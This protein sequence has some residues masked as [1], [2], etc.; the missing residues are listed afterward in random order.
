MQSEDNGDRIEPV[1]RNRHRSREL[2]LQ[3]LYAWEMGDKIDWEVMLERIADGGSLPVEV[4]KYAR[5]LVR[6]T[7][8]S[9]DVI[10]TQVSEQAANWELRR[11]AA[12]DR[13]ILRL[14]VAELTWFSSVPYKVVIDEAVELAKAFGTE[15]SG[16][17]VNGIVDSIYKKLNNQSGTSGKEG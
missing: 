13:N 12:I 7:I 3:A 1:P 10:D 15:G 5:E 4:R 6:H 8:D 2:A 11:M 14:A 9:L 16:K 17:F